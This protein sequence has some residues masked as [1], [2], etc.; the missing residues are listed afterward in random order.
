MSEEENK[1]IVI[2]NKVLLDN[3]IP[4]NAK[5]LFGVIVNLSLK[6]GACWASNAYFSELFQVTVV[7]V[8]TW[9]SILQKHKLIDTKI[10]A[11]NARRIY[12]KS[13]LKKTLFDY[14]RK[15]KYI[16]K[17]GISLDNIPSNKIKENISKKEPRNIKDDYDIKTIIKVDEKTGKKKGSYIIDYEDE[18]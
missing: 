9:I 15:L 10:Y 13:D 1:F 14:L 16:I 2:P 4:A 7:S 17:E 3:K 12:V 8:S 11:N 18:E 5:L 6:D